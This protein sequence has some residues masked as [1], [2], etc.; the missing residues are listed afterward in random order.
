[1]KALAANRRFL[2]F[3]LKRFALN[4]E[5]VVRAAELTEQGYARGETFPLSQY[6]ICAKRRYDSF[7]R[8]SSNLPGVCRTFWKSANL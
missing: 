1:M 6:V 8:K 2:C 7:G 4:G 3:P 5:A